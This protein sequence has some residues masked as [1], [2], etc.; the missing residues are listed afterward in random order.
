MD[1][2]GLP[3]RYAV[4]DAGTNSIKFHIAERAADGGW[5]TVADRAD[6]TRLGE[7]LDETGEISAERAG[8]HRDGDRRDGRRGPP[9][10]VLAIVAV[11]TAGLRIARNGAAVVAAIRERTGVAVEVI[12][13]DEESRLAYLAVKSALG[14]DEGAARRVRH[15]RRQHAA[16]VRPRRRAWTSASAWTSARSATRSGSG[17]TAWSRPEILAEALAAIAAD[18]DRLEAGRRWTRSS[19]WA[20]PSRTSPR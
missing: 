12:S 20:V 7:G 1:P 11:G 9:Q 15:G 17:S 6:I 2:R 13:G 16:D 10:R 5:R 8:P 18:L 14:M 4:I 3:E 19:A